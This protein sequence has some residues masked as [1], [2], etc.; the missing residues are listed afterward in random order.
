MSCHLRRLED[1]LLA[2]AVR[3]TRESRERIHAVIQEIAGE[4]D[5]QRAC[6]PAGR[7]GGGSARCWS[8]RSRL[9]ILALIPPC[10]ALSASAS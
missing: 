4:E 7:S 6:L 1:V 2:A 5:C 9:A 10:N 3:H 8:R